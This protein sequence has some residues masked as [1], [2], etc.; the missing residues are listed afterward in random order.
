MLLQAKKLGF[1]I[2]QRQV[3]E[4]RRVRQNDK[5]LSWY[6]SSETEVS[7]QWI[8]CSVPASKLQGFDVRRVRRRRE[9]DL[10]K[11]GELNGKF[12]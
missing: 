2:Y 5:R 8:W 7:P 4:L 11:G 3:D 12:L 9:C 10:C 1:A 6:V